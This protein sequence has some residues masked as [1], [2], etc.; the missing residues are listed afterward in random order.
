ML[1]SRTA[2]QVGVGAPGGT[3]AEPEVGLHG[4]RAVDD[5][6]ARRPQ[7]RCRRGLHGVPGRRPGGQRRG[8]HVGRRLRVEVADEHEAAAGGEHPLA[9]QVAEGVAVHGRDE[10][11]VGQLDG[12]GVVAVATGRER[13]PGDDAGLGAGDRDA[14]GHPVALALDLVVGIRRVGEQLGEQAQHRR[15]SVRE[16][17][18]GEQ[19]P[20][21]IGGHRQLRAVALQQLGDAVLVVRARAQQDGAGEDGAA[22]G[23]L[24]RGDAPSARRTAPA[25]AARS[26]GRRVAGTTTR[27]RPL[28][29]VV[30][31][32]SG[33]GCGRGSPSGGIS[34]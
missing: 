20:V 17:R 12:V 1:A 10:P 16:H 33:T 22:G 14:L 4:A 23:V 11:V 13:R 29:S 21:G 7:L 18:R 34:E 2:G 8:D 26:A 32:A 9:V 25:A 31:C 5:L 15:Q 27:R 30:S 28:G 3:A 24:P 6:D 19:Q